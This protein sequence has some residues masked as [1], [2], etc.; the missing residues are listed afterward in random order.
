[1]RRCRGAYYLL[2][3]QCPSTQSAG[4]GLKHLPWCWQRGLCTTFP[5]VSWVRPSSAPPLPGQALEPE[6]LSPA[7]AETLSLLC[8]PRSKGQD[9]GPNRSL[10]QTQSSPWGAARESPRAEL[11]FL[12]NRNEEK[13]QPHC[14]LGGGNLTVE[15]DKCYETLDKVPEVNNT[16]H[17]VMRHSSGRR[18]LGSEL[19]TGAMRLPKHSLT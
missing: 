3:P 4:C 6:P 18:V 9:S 14:P 11:F 5:C 13:N 17:T 16:H 1:M 15:L 12:Q 8:R 7:E 10:T 2:E 19:A